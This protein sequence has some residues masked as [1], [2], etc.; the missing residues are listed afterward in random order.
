MAISLR[1]SKEE[2]QAIKSKAKRRSMTVSGLIRDTLLDLDE[3]QN[4]ADAM[5]HFVNSHSEEL[6]VVREA[7][8]TMQLTLAENNR[9]LNKIYRRVDLLAQASPIVSKWLAEGGQ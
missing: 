7:I 3:R 9:M 4:L 2:E 1:L 8:K 5:Q 6:K